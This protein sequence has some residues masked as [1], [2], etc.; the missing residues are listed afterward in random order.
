MDDTKTYIPISNIMNASLPAVVIAPAVVVAPAASLKL[1]YKETVLDGRQLSRLRE[2]GFS[3]GMSEVLQKHCNSFPIRIFIVDNSS[4]MNFVDGQRLVATGTNAGAPV[5]LE[6]FSCTRWEELQ[7]TIDYHAEMAALLQAQTIFR[8]L[9]KP[10]I[11]IPQEFSIGMNGLSSITEDLRIAKDTI[12]RASPLGV[13]PLSEHLKAIQTE[14]EGYA[15]SLRIEGKRV[16]VI[17]ATDGLPSDARG[18]SGSAELDDFTN[19]LRE[20]EGLPIRLVIRLCTDDEKVVDFYNSLDCQLELSMKVISDFFEE[21]QDVY[22]VNPWANY[23][24]PL[25]RMRELGF[26]HRIFDLLDERKL[27]LS[28][29]TE[30]CI[31]LFG[32]GEFD[33]V[34]DPAIDFQG[35]LTAVKRIVKGENNYQWHPVKMKL[36]PLVSLRELSQLYGSGAKI[37]NVM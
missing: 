3:K 5:K 8:F 32:I 23:S 20:L 27:G 26:Q 22:A 36:K 25:Q 30:Y 19:A 10:I 6:S 33:G 31:F 37:C 13:T 4:S 2:Q 28:E 12:Q 1:E 34:P 29:L 7:E 16:A 14:L 11:K 15:P 18:I 24:L 9:N 35:F 21:A 17:L